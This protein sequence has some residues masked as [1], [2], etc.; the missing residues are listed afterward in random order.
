MSH[1]P[2]TSP[3]DWQEHFA[4]EN[5]CYQCVCFECGEMFYGHKRSVACRECVPP[6]EESK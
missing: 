2:G 6:K 4:H 3:K 5:G 1:A